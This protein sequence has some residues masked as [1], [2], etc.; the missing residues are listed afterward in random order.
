MLNETLK[1]YQ[2]YLYYLGRLFAVLVFGPFL[3]YRGKKYRDNILI[4]LGL[5]LILWDGTKL[6]IQAYYNDYSY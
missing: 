2:Q 4:L 5:L 6:I 3:V 1:L